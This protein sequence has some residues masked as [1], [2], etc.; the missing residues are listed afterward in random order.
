MTGSELCVPCGEREKGVEEQK[1]CAFLLC[2][3]PLLLG[4]SGKRKASLHKNQL[5]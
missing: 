1:V 3:F 2:F 5:G 4:L